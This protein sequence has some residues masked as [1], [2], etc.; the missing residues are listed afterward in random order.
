MEDNN[1]KKW[2]AFYLFSLLFAILALVV[3]LIGCSFSEP[4]GDT[5][6]Y[7]YSVNTTAHNETHEDSGIDEISVLGLSGLLAD[8]Q[9]VLD[10]EVI[11]AIE[12]ASPLTLPATSTS[13]HLY[14]KAN[15]LYVGATDDVY[16]FY[17]GNAWYFNSGAKKVFFTTTYYAVATFQSV[18]TDSL[19]PIM[20][21]YH[22]TSS[23]AIGDEFGVLEMHTRDGDGAEGTFLSFK[24]KLT[25]ASSGNESSKLEVQLWDGGSP[26]LAMYLTGEGILYVDDS[27]ETFDVYDDAMI[28]K[29]GVGEGKKEVL[30]AIGVLKKKYK[31][32]EEGKYILDDDGKLISD[33]YMISTQNFI[34]LLSGGISQ[35]RDKID[36]LTDRVNELEERIA[37]LECLIK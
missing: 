30:E 36:I 18:R 32:N 22:A 10:V 9:H 3:F 7:I 20:V 23:P 12:N 16:S 35:N 33:G 15:R 1:I 31:I 8:N 24:G 5:T 26:N 4:T 6:T 28:L 14:L 13:G 37:I 19:G 29:Q 11:D 25:N 34:K 2:I 17:D 21:L 27:Y